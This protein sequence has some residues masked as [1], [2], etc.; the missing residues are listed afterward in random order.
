MNFKKAALRDELLV[1]ILAKYASEKEN[2]HHWAEIDQRMIELK[3]EDGNSLIS[4]EVGTV[5]EVIP[6]EN[7][8]LVEFS[9]R[10]LDKKL[11]GRKYVYFINGKLK[12]QEKQSRQE[13]EIFRT[14]AL[15]NECYEVED[16]TKWV[17]HKKQKKA[18]GE[19]V[20]NKERESKETS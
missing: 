15:A 14:L 16:E 20:M 1:R 7:G 19:R 8:E 4:N 2:D 9:L 12:E 17:Y 5:A 18:G 13:R 10:V 3:G 6:D 11:A